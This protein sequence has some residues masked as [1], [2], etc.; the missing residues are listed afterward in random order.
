M[1]QNVYIMSDCIILFLAFQIKLIF[2]PPLNSLFNKA[3][4]LTYL[5]NVFSVSVYVR[6][7]EDEYCGGRSGG[8]R[9]QTTVLARKSLC[10]LQI[11]DGAG[12]LTS[13]SSA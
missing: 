7:L 2:F 8:E 4:P 5:F 12:N 6:I 9:R 11:P 1:S 13:A 10:L 3:F